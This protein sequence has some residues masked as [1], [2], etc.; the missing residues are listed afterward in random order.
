MPHHNRMKKQAP[1]TTLKRVRDEHE[2]TT[3]R[4]KKQLAKRDRAKLH[5][6]SHI[7]AF[8]NA[9]EGEERAKYERDN[10]VTLPLYSRRR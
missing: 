10:N 8:I 1:K 4:L 6:Q 9:L 2:V 7:I 5:L 3:V